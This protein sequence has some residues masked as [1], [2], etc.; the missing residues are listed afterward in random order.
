[1]KL[2]WSE[3]E[4]G[5]KL[6]ILVPYVDENGFVQYN[7]QESKVICV[8]PYTKNSEISFVN[9]RFKYTDEL[10]KRKRVNCQIYDL[11]NPLI[12]YYYTGSAF[13]K[14]IITYED[15]S[16]LEKKYK[17]ILNSEIQKYKDKQQQLNNYIRRLEQMQY[18]KF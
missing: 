15:K 17:E 12:G 6:H 16:L 9:V 10:G 7:Y 5:T 3:L 11:D 1:M 18:E 14:I 4:K 2:N 8:K 13:R